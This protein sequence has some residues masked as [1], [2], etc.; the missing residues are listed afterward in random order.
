[1]IYYHVVINFIPHAIQILPLL[2]E[3]I[4]IFSNNSVQLVMEDGMDKTGN[5]KC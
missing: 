5:E 4:I 2:L 3:S 1:M